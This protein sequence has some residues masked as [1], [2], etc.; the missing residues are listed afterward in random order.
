MC[1]Q[2]ERLEA[3][4]GIKGERVLLAGGKSPVF[5]QGPLV[6]NKEGL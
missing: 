3:P 2:T 6:E 4:S 1:L 5:S